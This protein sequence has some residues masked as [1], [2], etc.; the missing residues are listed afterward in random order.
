MTK[1]PSYAVLAALL[2]LAGCMP[3]APARVDALAVADA[4]M[5]NKDLKKLRV[6]VFYSKNTQN[7]LRHIAAVKAAAGPFSGQIT[8]DDQTVLQRVRGVLDGAFG[9][10][11]TVSNPEEAKLQS[12][13]LLAV[14]DL[15]AQIK[16]YSFATT[17][18]DVAVDFRLPDLQS[19]AM[20]KGYGHGMVPYP[21]FTSR[22]NTSSEAALKSF[23]LAFST[24]TQLA[25]F[26]AA[27]PA[28]APAAGFAAA[29]IIAPAKVYR[30]EV[31]TPSFHFPEDPTRFALV[32]GVERYSTLPPADHAVRDAVAVK[33]HLLAL[34]YPE[35][36]L[37][38]LTDGKAVKS[39]LEK[40][41]EAWLPRNTDEN[42]KVF[43]YFSGHGAPDPASGQAYLVPWDGDPKF[44]ETT[45]YPIKRFYE[46][47]NALQAKEVLV[48]MDSCFSGAGGRSVIAKGL[49]PLVG[50]VDT[51]LSLAGRVSAVAAAAADETTGADEESGH[52]LFTYQLLK[53]LD[54]SAG[55]ATLKGLY[56]SLSPKVRDAA[57]RDNRDQTPQL[58]GIGAS[59]L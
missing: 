59:P 50:K 30:S 53:A 41:L 47:L 54:A 42:S 12:A 43:V 8:P 52:G 34:G 57:R 35:R 20:I 51:G 19:V 3:V 28:A 55:K 45:G 46:K 36:N 13:Q 38:F 32:V 10:T 1:N 5:Y 2:G 4:S 17:F 56:D 23:A 9:Q 15:Y 29:P 16:T 37:V 27:A 22:W 18:L 40:Y 39:A 21:A 31:E 7:A 6:A 44:I 48:A 14:V 26:A 58:I 25:G 49:R 24:N 33:A 11:V